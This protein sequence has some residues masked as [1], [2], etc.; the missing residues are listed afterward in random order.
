MRGGAAIGQPT[1]GA[2]VAQAASGL[3]GALRDVRTVHWVLRL[4]VVAEFI[5]HGT[6]G[7]ITKAGWVPYFGVVG[8]PASVA[9]PLMPVVGTVDVALALLALVRP[10]RATLLYMAVWGLWTA[11]LRPLSGE[12]PWEFLERAGNF[13]VP[14]ALF[15]LSG[16]ARTWRDWFALITPGPVSV[17]RARQVGWI[18]RLTT[19]LLLVGHGG[20]GAVMAKAEWLSFFGVV[21]IN[22]ATATAADLT[23]RLGWFEMALGLLV[24]VRPLP[25]VLAFVFIWKVG[26]ELLRPLAGQAFWEV[27]ERGGSY[28][29]PLALLCLSLWANDAEAPLDGGPAAPA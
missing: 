27:V 13:G 4:G 20:F 5:G 14:L 9:W 24:L 2:G 7:I 10:M 15:W 28:A 22:A 18:L 6:F 11:L 12:G 25:A 19:A 29:A 1:V 3:V 16:P 26:V 8:I 23:A 21:G 17:A